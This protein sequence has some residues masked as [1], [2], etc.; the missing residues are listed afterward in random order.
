MQDKSRPAQDKQ[1]AELNKKSADFRAE[2]KQLKDI[3]LG[4]GKGKG[5]QSRTSAGGGH[6]SGGRGQRERQKG[7]NVGAANDVTVE[8][9]PKAENQ[10]QLLSVAVKCLSS[11][12]RRKSTWMIC[13]AC[14]GQRLQNSATVTRLPSGCERLSR[15]LMN[16]GTRYRSPQLLTNTSRT[17]SV[18]RA[19]QLKRA[20]QA[21]L[22]QYHAHRQRVQNA[23]IHATA[24]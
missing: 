9:V 18:K 21:N 8:S 14:I 5:L 15:E 1:A 13:T 10:R 20:R 12:R 24:A 22:R 6:G 7:G 2:F 23:R 17:L 4:K 11:M 19:W 16:A 3:I